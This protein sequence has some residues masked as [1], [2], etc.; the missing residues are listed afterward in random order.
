MIALLQGI[1]EV[2]AFV[3]QHNVIH[4]DIKPSNLIRRRQDNKIVLIDFGA[5]KQIGSQVVNAQGK[6]RLT[7][8]VGTP[9]YMPSEQTQNNPRLCS[10]IY[11]VGIV[12][13]QALTGL[14]ALQLPEDPNTGE[15]TCRKGAQVS[16]QVAEVLEKMVR[17]DFRQRYQSAESALQALQG[18]TTP[19]PLSDPTTV[20]LPP[21]RRAFLWQ[22]LI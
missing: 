9:G 18:L 4:R 7:V 10:D 13:I 5:V 15:I 6:T 14:P 16:R 20:L 12:G 11:A 8:A 3:H 22:A 2:L 19:M 21:K 1:L 17:Y